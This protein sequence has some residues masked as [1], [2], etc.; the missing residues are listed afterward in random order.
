MRD[1]DGAHAALL[2]PVE[3]RL[4]V[5]GDV[6]EVMHLHE[7]HHLHAQALER[8]LHL[9]DAVLAAAGPDLCRYEQAIA[10]A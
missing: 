10:H 2:L 1:A 5:C 9:L 6:D 8:G 3:Q 4:G 7:V